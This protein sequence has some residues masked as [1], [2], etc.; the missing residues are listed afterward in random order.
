MIS[1]SVSV[2]LLAIMSQEPHVQTSQGPKARSTR[3]T[4]LYSDES[5]DSE[6][7]SESQLYLY[8]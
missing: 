1:I 4:T 7:Y 5:I 2:C 3:L 8:G 6:C